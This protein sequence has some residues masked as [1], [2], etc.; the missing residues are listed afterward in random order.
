MACIPAAA[1]AA[2]FFWHPM[3]ANPIKTKQ[4]TLGMLFNTLFFT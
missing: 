2:G 1:G 3:A 4:L